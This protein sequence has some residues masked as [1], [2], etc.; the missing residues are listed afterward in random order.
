MQQVEAP[1][2]LGAHAVLGGHR[3]RMRKEKGEMEGC[4]PCIAPNTGTHKEAHILQQHGGHASPSVLHWPPAHLQ[5]PS[6]TCLL[7][8]AGPEALQSHPWPHR[9]PGAPGLSSEQSVHLCLPL[10]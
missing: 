10:T 1:G 5:A 2:D 7:S 6:L 4:T 3:M 9:P 8:G